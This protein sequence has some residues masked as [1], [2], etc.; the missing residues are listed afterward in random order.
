[1]SI[2]PHLLLVIAMLALGACSAQQSPNT[3]L[4]TP[5]DRSVTVGGWQLEA[6]GAF[7]D[8]DQATIRVDF[9]VRRVGDPSRVIASPSMIAPVGEEA[10][11]QTFGG[12]FDVEVTVTSARTQDGVAVT[13]NAVVRDG[14]SVKSTLPLRFTIR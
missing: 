13:A 1:M 3:T 5:G 11:M 6:R 4:S 10:K 14:A 12:E 9:V 8:P 2:R 7:A